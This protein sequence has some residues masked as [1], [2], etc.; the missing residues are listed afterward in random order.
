MYISKISVVGGHSAEWYP[1]VHGYPWVTEDLCGR[2]GTPMGQGLGNHGED[3]CLHK[4]HG[5]PWG[6]GE[7]AS[8]HAGEDP[9]PPPADYLPDQPQL[10]PGTL[11]F[12]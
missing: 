2:W 12:Q 6:L 7:V 11:L 8:V 4:P 3:V 10:P 5:P 9:S 1:P